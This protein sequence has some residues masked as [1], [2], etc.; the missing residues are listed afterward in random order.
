MAQVTARGACGGGWA[1]SDVRRVVLGGRRVHHHVDPLARNGP[2]IPPLDGREVDLQTD[3]TFASHHPRTPRAARM[4]PP[5][6]RTLVI[7][8]AENDMGRPLS[9]TPGALRKRAWRE[10]VT[11]MGHPLSQ[12][13]EA[14]R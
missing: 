1:L 9:Q 6:R 12:T 2:A 10:R 8:T 4:G 3:V 11:R 7:R 13:P 5:T 14:Q